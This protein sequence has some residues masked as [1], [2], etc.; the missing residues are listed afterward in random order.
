MGQKWRTYGNSNSHDCAGK[1][2]KLV[3]I[4]HNHQFMSLRVRPL[5]KPCH[6][7]SC[8]INHHALLAP[9]LLDITQG[10]YMMPEVAGF[11]ADLGVIVPID[12]E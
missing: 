5:D 1:T 4:E 8:P 3:I 10:L 6:A 12:Q 7:T 11:S 9:C 2:G